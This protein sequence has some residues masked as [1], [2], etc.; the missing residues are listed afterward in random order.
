MFKVFALSVIL[1]MI[2]GVAFYFLNPT[3]EIKNLK[4]SFKVAHIHLIGNEYHM[5][6]IFEV[7]NPENK[8]ILAK[9]EINLSSQKILANSIYKVIDEK[10]GK[11]LN[12]EVKNDYIIIVTIQLQANEIR[13]FHVLL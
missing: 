7:K 2:T 13:R 4:A 9:V 3:I 11:E 1:L 10:T 6:F 5:C 8:A 12:F